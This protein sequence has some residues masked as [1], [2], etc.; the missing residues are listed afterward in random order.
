MAYFGFAKLV[1]GTNGSERCHLHEEQAQDALDR[2]VVEKTAT[3]DESR[4]NLS[5]DNNRVRVWRP[6]GE[7]LNL[8]IAVTRHT[9][10]TAGV[11]VWYH[12]YNIRRA[13]V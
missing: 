13:L 6:P 5:S 2:P 8:A 3:S 10:P 1:E 12:F 9:A 4:F 7:R 11:M